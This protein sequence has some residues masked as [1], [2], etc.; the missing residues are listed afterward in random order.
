MQTFRLEALASGRE[1][2][3]WECSSI[4][5]GTVWVV[6]RSEEDAR[7]KVTAATVKARRGRLGDDSPLPPWKQADL[8]KCTVEQTRI[9][10]SDL[11][12]TAAGPLI[13]LL[14]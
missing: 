6:A 7:E 5:A 3:H 9:V 2:P 11:L 13:G 8:V 4:P 1:S 14:D 10:P 12:I